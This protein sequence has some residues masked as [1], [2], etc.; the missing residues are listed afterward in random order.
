MPT[1]REIDAGLRSRNEKKRW[2]AAIDAGDLL[3]TRPRAVWKL[4]LEHGSSRS[5]DRRTAVA[6]CMLEHLLEEYFAEYFPLLEKEIRAG[7]RLLGD[8]FTRCWK[9]G[10]S[11]SRLNSNRWDRLKTVSKRVRG[12]AS[13]HAGPRAIGSS[14]AA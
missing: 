12:K 8:T 9:F 11:K 10:Q 1:V 2:A 7:N 3:Y 13:A 14:R 6:T 4:I 5:E